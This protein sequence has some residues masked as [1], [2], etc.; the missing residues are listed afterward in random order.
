MKWR[1]FTHVSLQQP[2]ACN[3]TA[4]IGLT[5]WSVCRSEVA[6]PG[7]SGCDQNTKQALLLQSHRSSKPLKPLQ[8]KLKLWSRTTIYVCFLDLNDLQEIGL[9]LHLT[10]LH[11][12]KNNGLS[13]SVKWRSCPM[14]S[15]LSWF[16]VFFISL[17]VDEWDLSLCVQA[18]LF[19]SNTWL[20]YYQLSGVH[21][22]AVQCRLS[23][24]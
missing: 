14:I 2:S 22:R 15:W 12:S 1:K 4:A 16:S 20:A 23:T 11:L 19:L 3:S 17:P 7:C 18:W 10:E 6:S 13:P 8:Q 21:P 9:W 24:P 5:G